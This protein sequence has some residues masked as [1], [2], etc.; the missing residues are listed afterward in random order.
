VLAAEAGVVEDEFIRHQPLHGVDGFLAGSAHLLHLRL[1]AEGLGKG[2]PKG[3][4]VRKGF[5]VRKILCLAP[6]P[7]L[8][9]NIRAAICWSIAWREAAPSPLALPVLLHWCW[10]GLVL[11]PQAFGPSPPCCE[12]VGCGKT[13][14]TLERCTVLP[15]ELFF[16]S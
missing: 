5:L 1:Q 15:P 3:E 2:T 6:S 11:G 13:A 8:F 7:A 14:G 9:P 4:R 16:A 10:A 12:S